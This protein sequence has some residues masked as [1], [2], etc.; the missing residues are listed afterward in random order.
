MRRSHTPPLDYGAT[1]ADFRLSRRLVIVATALAVIVTA[2][3]GIV[4]LLPARATTLKAMVTNVGRETMR[5]IRVTV[6]GRTY[7]LGDLSVKEARAIG[8]DPTGESHIVLTYVDEGGRS[9]SLLVDCYFE[10][11]DSGT[12]AVD[13]ADGKVVRVQQHI[14]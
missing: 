9:Q 12:I 8:V 1:A 3:V 11:T 2:C 14:E 5:D 4:R 6:T 13:V 7:P 10:P